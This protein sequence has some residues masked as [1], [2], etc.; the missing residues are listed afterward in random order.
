[1]EIYLMWDLSTSQSGPN[2]SQRLQDKSQSKICSIKSS[3]V[4]PNPT[5]T[6][7]STPIRISISITTISTTSRPP[8]TRVLITIT[9]CTTQWTPPWDHPANTQLLT[10]C[11]KRSQVES[12]VAFRAQEAMESQWEETAQSERWSGLLTRGLR[13]IKTSCKDPT[14]NYE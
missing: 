1:M 7:R 6:L 4:T 10:R 8:W 2:S 3:L 5:V 11:P 13:S 14:L 12:R 9:T